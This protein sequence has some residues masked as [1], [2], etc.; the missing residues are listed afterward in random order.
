MNRAAASGVSAEGLGQIYDSM[1]S[2]RSGGSNPS[3]WDSLSKYGQ[4]VTG[5]RDMYSGQTQSGVNQNAW[6]SI[7]NYANQFTGRTPNYAGGN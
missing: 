7:M 3:Y 5:S 6:G 1:S 4:I 2:Y